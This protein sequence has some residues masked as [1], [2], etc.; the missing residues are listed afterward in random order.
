METNKIY[1]IEEYAKRIQIPTDYLKG[2]SHKSNLSIPRQVYWYYL[3]S[4]GVSLTNISVEFERNHSTII[5][6]INRIKGFL[7]IK[8]KTINQHLEALDIFSC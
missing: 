5:Y 1:S 3:F 4:K 2:N 6:G 7:D 8:D